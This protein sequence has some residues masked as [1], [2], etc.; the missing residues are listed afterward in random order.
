MKTKRIE[1]NKVQ[2]TSPSIPQRSKIRN[3]LSIHTRN[4]NE[5]QKQFLEIATDKKTKMIFV[6]GQQVHPRHIWWSMQL[7]NYLMKEE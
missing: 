4:L 3:Q 2:D 7:S 5:K 6:S 1:Q